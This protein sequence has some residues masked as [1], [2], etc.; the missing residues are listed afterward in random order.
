MDGEGGPRLPLVSLEPWRR[1][2]AAAAQLCSAA[3]PVGMVSAK[4]CAGVGFSRSRAG[5]GW[6]GQRSG[7]HGVGRD[8]LGQE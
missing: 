8:G 5:S 3:A 4:P 7:G 6:G 2:G 1:P